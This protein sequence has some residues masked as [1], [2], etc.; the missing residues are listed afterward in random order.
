M[1]GLKSFKGYEDDLDDLDRRINDWIRETQVE[2]VD[3][4]VTM[5]FQAEQKSGDLVYTVLFQRDGE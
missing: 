4:E 2:V 5:A 1:I 3:V